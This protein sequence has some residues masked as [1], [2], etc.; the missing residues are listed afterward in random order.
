MAANGGNKGIDGPCAHFLQRSRPNV[1]TWPVPFVKN[2]APQ[3]LP[4]ARACSRPR[5]D[6]Q[7]RRHAR[8][9]FGEVLPHLR[10]PVRTSSTDT[11]K[12]TWTRG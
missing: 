2:G 12:S 10:S 11:L 5:S 8:D 4:R 1:S 9:D 7:T 3:F 6:T